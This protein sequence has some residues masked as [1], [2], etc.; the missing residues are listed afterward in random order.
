MDECW[1]RLRKP[2][3]NANYVRLLPDRDSHL[4]QACNLTATLAS[5]LSLSIL[6]NTCTYATLRDDALEDRSNGV[7]SHLHIPG[8]TG[9]EKK[10]R[11][12]PLLMHIQPFVSLESLQKEGPLM[13][14]KS[15]SVA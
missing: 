10:H 2:T 11:P 13:F 15:I 9:L 12:A 4:L 1:Q 5:S 8:T 3:Q 7:R 6:L 14:L